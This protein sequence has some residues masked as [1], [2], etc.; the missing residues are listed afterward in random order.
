MCHM[1]FGA[2]AVKM[3]ELPC[4]KAV[5]FHSRFDAEKKRA[6]ARYSPPLYLRDA[7]ASNSRFYPEIKDLIPRNSWISPPNRKRFTEIP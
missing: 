4:G 6:G 1:S 7:A 5:R 2:V 3:F